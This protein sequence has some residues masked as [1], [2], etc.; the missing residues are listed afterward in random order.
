M[1]LP[2]YAMKILLYVWPNTT[3]VVSVATPVLATGKTTERGLTEAGADTEA[4][5]FSNLLRR[6]RWLLTEM[7]IIPLS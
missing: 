1:L 3:L 2:P 6:H 5:D 4:N 7:H